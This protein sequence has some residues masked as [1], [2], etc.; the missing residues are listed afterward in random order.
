MAWGSYFDQLV[1]WNQ[2]IDHEK[3][4]MISYEELK[5]VWYLSQFFL[6][7]CTVQLS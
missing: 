5:E 7:G 4:M 1:E 3:I 6:D 2:Y